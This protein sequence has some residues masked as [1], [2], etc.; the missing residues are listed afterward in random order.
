M[1]RSALPRLVPPM[2]RGRGWLGPLAVAAFGGFLRF[3]RLGVPHAFVFDE[4]YYAKDAYSL[5]RFGVERHFADDADETILRGGTDVFKTCGTAEECAAY[6]AHPPLGKWLIGAGEWLFGLTPFGWRFAAALAGTLSVLVLARVARRMTRSTLLGCLAGLLLAL[7]GLHLVLSRSALLD[8]FLTFWVL[9]GFACLVADRDAARARLAEWYRTSVVTGPAP[10][11][12]PRPWRLAAGLCLGAAIATK[13]TG[14]LFAVAFA[15]MTLVW[16]CG[17]RRAVGLRRP[18]RQAVRHDWPLGLAWL[19]AVPVAVYVAS[20]AGWFASAAGWG[21]AW[22]RAT[23]NGWAYFVFDS[24]R[25]LVDYQSQ[26]LGFHQGLSTGH[27]YQ[28]DPWSWPL[29]LRPTLFFYQA[30]RGTCGAASCSQAILGTGTPVIWYAGLLALLAVLVRY[31]TTR[32]WR[33]GA[34]V[35]AYAAGWLPWFYFALADDRT[36]YLFY[37]LPAVP[38]MIL[39]IVLACGLV[40]GPPGASSSRRSTAAALVGAFT[41]LALVNFWW[42]APVLTAEPVPYE[43]WLSRM[44]LRGWI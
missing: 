35:L 41:L 30:P 18:Y 33:A 42:L 40:L 17:A 12:G 16:D 37:A 24:L 5:I 44:L 6:V 39:A 31:A 13:W 8:V 11:L 27:D 23:S 29:L 2:P 9:A 28:S 21:R 32:D 36:M 43:V 34:V 10:R 7:D 3:D 26:V 14:L 19:G 22:D 25:S 20:F 15:I 4:T 38:F 1:P